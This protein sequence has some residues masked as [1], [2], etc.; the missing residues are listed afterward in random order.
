MRSSSSNKESILAICFLFLLLF[1]F[2]RYTAFIYINLSFILVSLL[3]GSAAVF[4]DMLWKKLTQA[5]GFI[6]STILLS[7]I[8]FAVVFPWSL[9]LKMAGKK[10]L[11]FTNR[12]KLFTGANL[13][14]PY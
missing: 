3:S 7:V 11:L 4:F 10:P 8:F 13:Q 12:N 9:V 2:T 14:N 6:S 1:L 5:L